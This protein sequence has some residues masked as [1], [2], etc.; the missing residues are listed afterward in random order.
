M[1][2][3]IA[4][5]LLLLLVSTTAACGGDDRATPTTPTPTLPTTVTETFTG[6]VTRN[7]AT[8]HPFVTRAGTVTAK[9]V[10]LSPESTAVVGLSLGTWNGIACQT[11]IANDRATQ[12][13]SVIGTASG[14]GNLCVR[15]YDAAGELVE[16]TSYEVQVEHPPN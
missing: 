14:T 2:R 13:I 11:V 16:L 7:G 12:G 5:A 15:L 1:H 6:T 4:R 10:T 8:T 9:I 3:S